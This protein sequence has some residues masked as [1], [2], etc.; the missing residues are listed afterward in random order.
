MWT[1]PFS[2]LT[3]GTIKNFYSQEPTLSVDFREP[4]L[5]SGLLANDPSRRHVSRGK[6]TLQ[7]EQTKLNPLK[8]GNKEKK[9]KAPLET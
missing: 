5:P 8:T 7:S 1:D 9:S 6:K 3:T 4:T 2:G